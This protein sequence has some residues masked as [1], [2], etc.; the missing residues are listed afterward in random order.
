ML[1]GKG[2]F[3]DAQLDGGNDVHNDSWSGRFLGAARNGNWKSDMIW[4]RVVDNK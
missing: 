3:E 1:W 2:P 4:Y